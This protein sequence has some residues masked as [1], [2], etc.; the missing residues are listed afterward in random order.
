[1]ATQTTLLSFDQFMDLPDQ[2][3]VLRELDEGA[4]IEMANPSFGH[5]Q[6]IVELAAL[7]R[8]FLD[9]S[10]L[11]FRTSTNTGFHLGP[12][13]VRA[14][15][16]CLV[17]ASRLEAMPVRR[18][19]RVGAPD[20]AVEVVSPSETALDL[21][22]KVEQYLHAGAVAVWEL[23]VDARLVLVYRRSG[24]TLRLT[25]GQ[26]LQEPELLPGLALPVDKIFAGVTI[27]S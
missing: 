20:L 24:E 22:R 3:G 2:E 5:G 18:G 8:N 14:P 15:D 7:L 23:Y 16:L 12:D 9:Q 10:G 6:V 25:S 26:T 13:T 17:R 19:A 21:R 11:E 27:S 4:L 1:M